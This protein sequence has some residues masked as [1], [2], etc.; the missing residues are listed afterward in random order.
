MSTVITIRGLPVPNGTTLPFGTGLPTSSRIR[1]LGSRSL[2]LVELLGITPVV[3][4]LMKFCS[5]VVSQ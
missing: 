3:P 4:Y 1:L 5:F 2:S